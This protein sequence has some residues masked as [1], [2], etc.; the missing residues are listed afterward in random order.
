ML[1]TVNEIDLD[2]FFRRRRRRRFHS[3]NFVFS[4][5][6]EIIGVVDSSFDLNLSLL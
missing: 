2:L 5:R 4:R 6:M 1:I 3:V